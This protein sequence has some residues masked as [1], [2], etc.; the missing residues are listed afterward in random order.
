MHLEPQSIDYGKSLVSQMR[1]DPQSTGLS[2]ALTAGLT[3]GAGG[4]LLARLL[5]EDPSLVTLAALLTGAGGATLG[6]RAGKSSQESENSRLLALR[7]A[8]VNNPAELE[9]MTRYPSLTYELT[10]KRTTF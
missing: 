3:S 5:T 10:K 8:G 7:R 4:A 6:Y 2:T 1:K 9:M